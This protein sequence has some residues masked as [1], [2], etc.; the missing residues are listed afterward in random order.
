MLKLVFLFHKSYRT[1]IFF[2]SQSAVLPF[3]QQVVFSYLQIS[4]LPVN[5]N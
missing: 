3:A 4:D 1:V 5:P 2:I